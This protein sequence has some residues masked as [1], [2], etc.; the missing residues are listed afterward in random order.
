MAIIEDD[1]LFIKE[2]EQ[3]LKLK[4]RLDKNQLVLSVY[5]QF[6]R[7]KSTFINHLLGES[8]L[9]T[10]I[11]PVTAVVTR[12]QYSTHPY[13]EVYFEDSS[14]ESISLETLKNY[15]DETYNTGNHLKVQAVTIG[16][17]AEILK[18]N[19]MIVDTPGIGSLHRNNTESAMD[20]LEKTD[21][22]VFMLSIDSPINEIELM[23]LKQIESA[24]TKI[25]YV[26]NKTDLVSAENTATYMKYCENMIETHTKS[27][28]IR[29]YP[30]SAVSD[31]DPGI[32]ELTKDI[33]ADFQRQHNDI[34][35]RSIEEKHQ[36]ITEHILNKLFMIS[37]S[38]MLSE[39]ETQ[40]I[41]DDLSHTIDSID[42]LDH[43]ACVMMAEAAKRVL[44]VLATQ[45][46]DSQ[47]RTLPILQS[48]V[49]TIAE[50]NRNAGAKEFY[51]ILN[52]TIDTELNVFSKKMREESVAYTKTEFENAARQY[53][54]QLQAIYN[55]QY[56]QLAKMLDITPDYLSF[57]PTISDHSDYR[58]SGTKQ[59]NTMFL[60]PEAFVFLLPHK[61]AQKQLLKRILGETEKI[62]QRCV[63]NVLS[64]D[65]Y[66]LSESIRDFQSAFH[67]DAEALKTSLKIFQQNLIEKQHQ[68]DDA[69]AI[70][71]TELNEKINAIKKINK[72][73][74]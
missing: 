19:L 44:E 53:S 28:H 73:L 61:V 13:A 59:S 38:L 74:E 25:Y 27:E 54:N 49:L 34:L 16:F 47:K 20:Y 51:A 70:F 30:I 18:N 45:H 39:K 6:K 56:E 11:I 50:N 33:Q 7:G 14:V 12:I 58:F 37:R 60:K 46:M 3:L 32:A 43:Q 55:Q 41:T 4:E 52:E 15:T 69:Q 48:K 31:H 71:K 1:P 40:T 21:A 57:E 66:R 8:I 68:T 67:Q 22:A 65:R 23:L 63:T 5:G 9:S 35:F 10:G 2:R 17:P 72:L 62:L 26:V 29:L 24:A 64:D 36:K 42:E